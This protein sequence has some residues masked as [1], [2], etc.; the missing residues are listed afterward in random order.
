MYGGGSKIGM[1]LGA[2]LSQLGLMLMQEKAKRQEEQRRIEAEK[3][4]FEMKKLWRDYSVENPTYG[5][6]QGDQRLDLSRE[7]LDLERLLGT[8]RLDLQTQRLGLDRDRF[9]WQQGTDA[10]DFEYGVGRDAVGDKRWDRTFQEQ[11]LNSSHNRFMDTSRLGMARNAQD[12]AAADAAYR[13][14]PRPIDPAL[15]AQLPHG[16]VPG[17]AGP[18]YY[19]GAQL[20]AQR[21]HAMLQDL[22]MDAAEYQA[23]PQETKWP[24]NYDVN[25]D[26]TIDQNDRLPLSTVISGGGRPFAGDKMYAG[27]VT[28]WYDTPTEFL[29]EEGPRGL[30]ESRHLREMRREAGDGAASEFINWL[31]YLKDNSAMYPP[32][33]AMEA[34]ARVMAG[35]PVPSDTPSPTTAAGTAPA[36]GLNLNRQAPTR[37]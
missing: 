22:L 30:R 27:E 25:E 7:G 5:E 29:Y 34:K 13:N 31:Y 16:L 23:A 9:D 2:G 4:A 20:P 26:G 21:Q 3:R 28:A 12:L 15:L 33:A 1:G 37:R 36:G 18:D 24:V 11:L 32:Q 19:E 8:G 35:K 17:Q 6:L 10:R 14:N